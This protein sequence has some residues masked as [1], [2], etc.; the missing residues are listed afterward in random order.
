MAAISVYLQSSNEAADHQL[1]GLA[2]SGSSGTTLVCAASGGGSGDTTPFPTSVV[3]KT[4]HR[5]TSANWNSSPRGAPADSGTVASVTNSTTIVT[6]GLTGWSNGDVWAIDYH[7][8]HGGF[9]K[10][11]EGTKT[12]VSNTADTGYSKLPRFYRSS[13]DGVALTG[14]DASVY[15]YGKP[16]TD[17]GEQDKDPGTTKWELKCDSIQRSYNNAAIPLPIPSLMLGDQYYNKVL[18]I[19]MRSESINLQGTLVDRG[20]PSASNPRLQTLF[21]LIRTQHSMTI[22]ATDEDQGEEEGPAATPDNPRAYLRLT[23]GSG[24]EPSDYTESVGAD[25]NDPTY[26]LN[27]NI[28]VRDRNY[29]IGGTTY[30]ANRTEKSYRGVVT[31][32][33]ATQQ[34]GRPDI[35]TWQMTF[36][37]FKNEHDWAKP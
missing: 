2:G 11:N 28:I 7:N 14:T 4:I 32:F 9:G 34:G 12:D 35:W 29:D 21:D 23:I 5:Y 22:A 26:D 24:Y 3:G 18:D 6:S 13:A 15:N 33:S 10:G 8:L 37:V 1:Y 30:G 27:K 16:F 36:Y 20:V 19:G 25:L 31:Q 17:T